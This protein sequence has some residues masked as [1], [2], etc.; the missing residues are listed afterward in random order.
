MLQVMLEQMRFANADSQGDFSSAWHT[1]AGDGVARGGP[2][3]GQLDL[4]GEL[5][6]WRA[7]SAARCL[8]LGI[9]PNARDCSR[10]SIQGHISS[11]TIKVKGDWWEF[12]LPGSRD[13]GSRLHARDP[14]PARH[15]PGPPCLHNRRCASR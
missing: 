14:G 7:E 5:Q 12:P 6:R 11:A 1:E 2:F 13:G 15:R 3:P 8:A 9:A 4:K 10:R